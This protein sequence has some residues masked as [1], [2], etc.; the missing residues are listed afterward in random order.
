[1]LPD[2]IEIDAEG[3]DSAPN[4]KPFPLICAAE[5]TAKPI[6]I[7]WL[8]EGYIERGSLNM[9]FGEPA[10]GKSLFALDW[11]FCLA[12]GIHWHDH[13]TE[14]TDV[15]VIA[16]EG[17]A[18]VG[19][20]LKALEV[21]YG[22]P[23]PDRLFISERPADLI[24]ENNAQWVADSI[25]AL[26]PNPGLIII[27]TLHRNM[28]GD[29]N[30]SSDIGQF[31]A[32]IDNHLK[33][34]G[35]AVLIV[36]HSGHGTAQRSR[37]SSSIRAAMDGEFSATKDGL[38]IVLSCTKAKDFEALKPQQFSLKSI[39]LPW[40]DDDGEPLKSVYLEHTGDA[41]P[42]TSKRKLSARDDAILTAL[43]EAIDKHGVEPSAEI[44]EKFA[45]FG[46]WSSAKVVHV[47]HWRERAYKTMT[48]DAEGEAA[49]P[50]KKM[51]FK[52]CRDRLLNQGF[53]VEY[54]GYCW[55]I[56]TVTR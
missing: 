43:S 41:Q 1:M 45:G 37:G 18:G 21:K 28:T 46:K 11:A 14:Q 39:E 2:E 50:A 44:K 48:I 12:H 40:L 15:V 54:G 20:R 47:D 5:L 35:A 4:A 52:R 49:A 19:R 10:A 42:T 34:L 9:L 24:D 33:P 25:T 13:A 26:C 6:I 38:S 3:P 29:E 53:T 30:S 27:D 56:D 16:G 32:N 51:A 17:F 55:R 31:V 22:R 36:H 8:L 23:S 7:Q